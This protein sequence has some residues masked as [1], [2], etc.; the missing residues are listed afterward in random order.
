VPSRPRSKPPTLSEERRC[1]EAGE[2]HV[3]GVDEVGRGAWAGPLTIGAVVLPPEGRVNGIRD[4]KL[5]TPARREQLFDRIAEWAVAWAVGHATEHECDELG[6]SDAQRLATHRAIDA[7]AVT[8][9]RV[10]LDGNWNYVDWLPSR[11]IVKGDRLCLSI[12]AA[13][14]MAKVVRDRHMIAEATHHPA[15]GFDANKGYPAPEH[16]MAL[17]GYGP[18]VIHRRSWAFMDDLPWTAARRLRR[19]A[20]DGQGRLFAA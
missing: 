16:V 14:V 6:M 13:S 3:V 11:T 4:S 7:L 15:Y 20:D 5:L 1:W 9:D 17:A 8:P 12:A 19:D 18:S 10:L 2:T